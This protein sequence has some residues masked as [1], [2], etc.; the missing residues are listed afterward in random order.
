LDLRLSVRWTTILGMDPGLLCF[1]NHPIRL[2]IQDEIGATKH[3]QA[4]CTFLS[5]L[6]EVMNGNPSLTHYFFIQLNKML[7]FFM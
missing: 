2:F 5:H 6:Y 3:M 7:L 1:I 4:L